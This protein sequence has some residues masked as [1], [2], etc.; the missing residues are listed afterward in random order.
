MVK[1]NWRYLLFLLA[2]H[3][4]YERLHRTIR[5]GFGKRNIYL[6]S[7][8][9]GTVLGIA[10]IFAAYI[11]GLKFPTEFYLPLIAFLPLA[12]AVDWFTQSAK[13]RESK[14][15]L[16]LSSGFLLGSSE[17][18]VF[19]LIIGGFFFQFLVALGIASFYALSIYLIA[20]KTKCL[21]SYLKDFNQI[22]SPSPLES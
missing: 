5:L 21:D 9:T 1:Q 13:L 11:F 16:R 14:N 12:A 4:P 19:L 6:C 22:Q 15:W 18:L 10:A 7:R 20:V 8:C 3:H 2:S 17:A